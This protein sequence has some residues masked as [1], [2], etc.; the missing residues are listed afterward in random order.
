MVAQGQVPVE[1]LLLDY[2]GTLSPL[3]VSRAESRVPAETQAIL[4]RI[5]QKIPVVVVT[6]KAPDFVIP[7]TPFATAWSTVNGLET[8]I[9][10]KVFSTSLSKPQLDIFSAAL[11]YSKTRLAAIGVDIE[12][13]RLSNEQVVGFCVD[14]RRSTDLT[15]AKKAA[16]QVARRLRNLSLY[17]C[18]FESDPFYDVYSV[19]AHKGRAVEAIRQ[20]LGLNSG[21]AFVGD[22]EMDNPAF[23]LSDL[24]IGVLHEDSQPRLCTDYSARFEDLEDSLQL[25][26]AQSDSCRVYRPKLCCDYH[27]QFENVT[28]FLCELW[29]NGLFFKS[30]FSSIAHLRGEVR[31]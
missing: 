24:S 19:P 25:N 27:V 16:N 20:L 31:E 26:S 7:R 8:K 22:S 29:D 5:S 6:S 1:A 21:V 4:K 2:D 12:E 17:V 23:L 13:K 11:K 30:N 14:W 9:G 3:H 15:R 28:D 18:G 10:D